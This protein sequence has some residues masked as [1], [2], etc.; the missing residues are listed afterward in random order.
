MG[1]IDVQT[2]G[3]SMVSRWST[4]APYARTIIDFLEWFEKQPVAELPDS[5]ERL[6]DKYFGIDRVQLDNERREM[7]GKMR[8]RLERK[9]T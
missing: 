9:R 6:V 2:P 1:W 7:I 4:V 8:E 5:P 3:E